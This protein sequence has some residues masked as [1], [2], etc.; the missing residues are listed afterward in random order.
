MDGAATEHVA[1]N[2]EEDSLRRK[3][4]VTLPPHNLV[5]AHV[6]VQHH[7]NVHVTSKDA[8]STEAGLNILHMANVQ[9]VAAVVFKRNLDIVIIQHLLLVVKCVKDML[10]KFAF[11]TSIS[12]EVGLLGEDGEPA[13]YHVVAVFVSDSETVTQCL[14]PDHNLKWQLV[15]KNH[16]AKNKLF[17]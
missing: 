17:W 8:K 13:L 15:H 10:R 3:D 6:K 1:N 9:P 7:T 12:A 14:V 11:V 4:T 2:V 16:V 5:D